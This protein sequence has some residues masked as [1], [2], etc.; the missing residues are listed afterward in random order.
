LNL[1][2]CAFFGDRAGRMQKRDEPIELDTEAF[3]QVLLVSGEKT[4][5]ALV[6]IFELQLGSS[7]THRVAPADR[8]RGSD[9]ETWPRDQVRL[10]QTA[11]FVWG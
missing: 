1:G 3:A 9:K 4:P 7:Q 10:R 8:I 2:P 6:G 11:A 5:W